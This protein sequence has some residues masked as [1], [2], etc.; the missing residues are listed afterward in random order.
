MRTSCP[1]QGG[2]PG[3]A[4]VL[5]ATHLLGLALG[6]ALGKLSE[7][8]LTAQALFA[9]AEEQALL[10]RMLR[11][12]AEI[13]GERWE[14]VADRHRPHYTAEQ[15]FRILRLRT[16]LG[17]SQRETAELFRVSKETVGRWEEEALSGRGG[18]DAF[19]L[20]QPSPPVR[21]FADV[22]RGVVKTMQLAGVGGSAL[23]AR[24]LARAGWK[25]SARTVGRIRRERWPTPRAPEPALAVPRAVRARR[26]NHI[27]M[28]D[29]TDVRGLFGLVT[30]KVAVAFDVFSRLPLSMRVFVK[31]PSAF[32]MATLVSRT[33]R[34]FGRPAHFVSDKGNC[35]R[36]GAFR[37]VLRR[38][39]ARPRFG[40]IGKK[41]SIALIERLWRTLKDTLGLRVLCPLVAE[42]LRRKVELGLIHYAHFRPHE[43]LGG[44]T[45]AEIYFGRTPAHLSAIP[46][47]RGRP[48]E[49]PMESPFRVESLDAERLLPVLVRNAA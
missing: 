18:E 39:G 42:D 20:I 4:A 8:G 35:F 46:P 33:A 1:P 26:P 32:E 23:I 31:E 25:V 17:L 29:L 21:R 24:T 49:G 44:A 5:R 36:G 10:V 28:A 47:P 6:S 16:L 14:K 3:L 30:F 34:R 9:K 37:R 48:G 12:A 45:P 38:L 19:A 15:R 22:A 7:S 2:G 43:A 11:E 13:L 41:G 40:A 27:W